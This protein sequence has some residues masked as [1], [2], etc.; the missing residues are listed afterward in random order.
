VDQEGRAEM[1]RYE[2]L[3][4]AAANLRDTFT[5]ES[6]VGVLTVLTVLVTLH[7]LWLGPA[8]VGGV[9]YPPLSDFHIYREAWPHLRAG[10][11]LYARYP[12]EGLF[13]YSPTFAMAMAPFAALPYGAAAMVWSLL[14][15]AVFAAGLA[16][17]PGLAPRARVLALLFCTVE[18]TTAVQNG[19]SNALIAG[20]ILLA[21]GALE[22]GRPAPAPLFLAL[23]I[24]IKPFAAA[25]CLLGAFY[26]ARGRL[27]L[28]AAGWLLALAA[29][30]LVLLS[31]QAL[32]GQYLSWAQQLVRDNQWSY[33]LSLFGW[34]NAWF[35]VAGGRE[36]LRLAGALWLAA[37]LVRRDRWADP[38]FRLGFLG[39]LLLWMVI[40][41][42]KADSATYVIAVTGVALWYLSR[43]RSWAGDALLA[44][45]LIFTQLSPTDLFPQGI[46][47]LLV[48]SWQLKALPCILVW[49]WLSTALL[50]GRGRPPP[51]AD[52]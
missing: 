16:A 49:L 14:N 21:Y 50:L 9:I 40:F 33:G 38:S 32:L 1:G 18:L 48:R 19:Q 45:V 52:R 44:V 36:L 3:R 10:W 17:L 42:H 47:D 6:L 7:K 26:P 43:P 2:S 27:L 22:R 41:N 24:L 51:P 13:L 28:A 20:L 8:V 39:S 31:P 11:D 46:K 30:P 35:G 25:A 23:A 34:L 29:L 5:P 4:R 37:A 12:G 15:T